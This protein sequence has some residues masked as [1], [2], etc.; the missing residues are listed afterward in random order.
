VLHLRCGQDI[1]A[2]LSDAGLPGE[3]A[4]WDDPLCEGPLREWPDDGARR[5]ERSAWLSARFGLT[6]AE[7]LAGLE[8][9]DLALARAGR[10]DEVVLWFEHDLFDQTILVFLLHRLRETAPDRTS[11]V[12]IGSHP[13]VTDFLGLGQLTADQLAGLFPGR[14]PVTADQFALADRAWMA[15]TGGDPEAV[16]RMG[17]D[18]TRPLPFL[19]AALRRYLAELPSTRNGLGQTESHGLAAFAAGADTPQHAFQAVQRFEAAPWMGDAMFYAVI[20][21]LALGPVPLLVPVAGRLPKAGDP[22][23]A[24]TRFEVSPEGR[25]VL[26]GRADWFRIARPTRWQGSVL[27]EGPEPLWR[28][29][30]QTERPVRSY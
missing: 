2:R 30:E 8:R 10:E 11:L 7:V 3:A 26:L 25:A 6:Q 21:L 29:D 19:G 15:L 28:W 18:E 1:L 13:E 22:A 16:W 9:S 23:I 20:R 5:E 12:C 24:A 17:P 4:A 14:I 27:L